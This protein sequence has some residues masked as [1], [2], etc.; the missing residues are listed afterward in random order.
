MS[1]GTDWSAARIMIAKKVTPY[2]M[3]ATITAN[4]ASFGS[5]SQG[6]GCE[7][8]PTFMSRSLITPNS[9]LN[10]QRNSIPIRKPETAHGKNTSAWYSPRK[11]NFFRSASAMRKPMT[12]CGTSEPTTQ[13]T[14]FHAIV[15]NA[16]FWNTA[17]KLSKPTQGVD[18]RSHRFQSWNAMR[19]PC[20]IGK[21]VNQ[22]TNTMAGAMNAS[23][24]HACR[25]RKG[26]QEAPPAVPTEPPE[27]VRSDKG[28][29]FSEASFSVQ[30]V[31]Q[32]FSSSLVV[33]LPSSTFCTS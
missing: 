32:D 12:S 5:A 27:R 18:V 33:M 11:R 25:A 3:F 9:A 21:Y 8:S 26:R 20:S 19:A 29:P 31:S 14:E 22:H 17:T 13:S 16:G 2:Q 28:Q 6:S 4:I 23:S 15:G 1:S 24:V 30:K 7:I 10:I